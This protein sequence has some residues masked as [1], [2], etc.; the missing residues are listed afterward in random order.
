MQKEQDPY[1]VFG[2]GME[3]RK[4]LE[5]RTVKLRMKARR[6]AQSDAWGAILRLARKDI[7]FELDDLVA[8]EARA[9]AEFARV[10][11]EARAEA[12]AIAEMARSGLLD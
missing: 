2:V 12:E 11:E 3:T 6:A 5:N 10:A 7:D 1:G 8:L 4:A 9:E